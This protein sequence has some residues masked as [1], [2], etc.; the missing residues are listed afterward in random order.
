M[1]VG[2]RGT[3]VGQVEWCQRGIEVPVLPSERAVGRIGDA[4]CELLV[5]TRR[6]DRATELHVVVPE[7]HRDVGLR[8]H[9]HERTILADGGRRVVE[10]V[11]AR[12]VGQVIATDEAVRCEQGVRTNH[13]GIAGRDVEGVDV[14]V[15]R[16]LALIERVG[17]VETRLCG[18]NVEV[19]CVGAV[20]AKVE[21]IEE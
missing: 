11:R 20:R 12:R 7:R 16:L 4:E 1:V 6:T 10:R 8:A 19:Q 18:L 9:V 3:A 5:E 13:S 17:H 15:L 2:E 21:T 14:L